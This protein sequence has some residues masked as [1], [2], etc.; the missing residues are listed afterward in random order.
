MAGAPRFIPIVLLQKSDHF[1]TSGNKYAAWAIEVLIGHEEST[2]I[3]SIADYQPKH[4]YYY[5]YQ[6]NKIRRKFPTIIQLVFS[7]S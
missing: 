4:S 6:V 5:S 1:V 3:L 2:Y 7:M